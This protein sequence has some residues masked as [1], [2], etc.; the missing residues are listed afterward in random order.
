MQHATL[1]VYRGVDGET[2]RTSVFRLHVI[3]LVAYSHVSIK[4]GTHGL[5]ISSWKLI[6]RL[7]GLIKFWE[8]I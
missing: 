8:F 3:Q 7:F 1:L 6:F 2:A 4:P 5:A